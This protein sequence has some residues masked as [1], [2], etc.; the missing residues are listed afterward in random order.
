MLNGNKLSGG[1]PLELGSFERLEYLDLSTNR[2]GKSNLANIGNLLK[3]HYLN[4][5]NN[6]LNSTFQY[7]FVN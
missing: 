7:K 4:L 2:F 1:I 5:S 6:K 3:I